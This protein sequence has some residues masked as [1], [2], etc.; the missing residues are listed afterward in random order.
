[1]DLKLESQNRYIVHINPQTAGYGQRQVIDLYRTIEEKFHGIPGVK[2]VGITSYTPMEDNNNG[3]SVV[4]QGK[5]DQH[6]DASDLKVNAEYFDSVG[7]RVVAGRGVTAQ[8]TA[9]SPTIAVVNEA[10]VRKLFKPGEN[11]IGQHFGSGPKHT[12]DYEIVGVVEDTVYTDVRKKDHL[13]YFM[14]FPQRAKSQKE[15]R[16]RRDD[17]CKR[18]CAED[19]PAGAADGRSDAQNAPGD[20]SEFERE[21]FS[22]VRR[23]DCG[24]VYPGQDAAAADDAVWRAGAAAGYAGDVWRDGVWSGAADC[25]DR[26]SHGAGGAARGRDADGDARGAAASGGGLCIGV[27]VAMVCVRF[28]VAQLYDVTR[29][30]VGVLAGSVIALVVAAALAGFIP[31]RRAASIEPARA[32]RAE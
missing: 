29:V 15:P 30:D 24:H 18:D 3:W 4:V 11:P 27:P 20:Q 31:A 8:D 1:V 13:M 7:T 12:G 21:N 25:R 16:A 28:V 22:D 32:L 14:A 26:D 17:V 23:A 9:T 5:P 2:K 10:F 6:V 19:G